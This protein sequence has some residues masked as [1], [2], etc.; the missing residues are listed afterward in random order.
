MRLSAIRV[1]GV[2]AALTACEEI[3]VP[4]LNNPDLESLTRNP[5]IGV[6]NTA[7][8]GM[9]INL[10]GRIGVE[11]SAMGILGKESYNLD[12]AEPRNVLSYLQGPIE[13][14]GFVQDLGWTEGYRNVVQGITILAAVDKITETPTP[15]TASY[16]LQQKEGIRGFVKTIMA[17]EL[18]TQVRIR[19]AVGIVLDVSADPSAP[20]GAVIPK[21]EALTRI[22]A[23]LNE[24]KTHLQNGGTA[25]AFQLHSGF[26][27][28]NTPSTFLRVN[29]AITARAEVYREQW[30]AALTALNES[31]IEATTATAAN[32]AR[33]AYHVFSL[34]SG[35]VLNTLFDQTPTRF[36]VHPSIL[37]GAQNR[38][39]GEPDLRLTQKTAPGTARTTVTV[40]GTHKFMNYPTNVSPVPIIKNEELILL[41]AEARYKTA[42][43]VGALAD[44][45]FIRVN[46]GGLAPLTLADIATEAAFVTE[47]LYNRTYSLLFE[48]G[49]RWVD[50]RRYGRLAQLPKINTQISEKTFPY[51][52]FPADECNQRNP[53]PQPACS[54]V[55]G[56]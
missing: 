19:D 47:L 39:S 38:P 32:L 44:L 1:I 52:M 7:T 24:A 13:P 3:T 14:G 16:S 15:T 42:D 51:V 8:V 22:V 56:Q 48:A 29:R 10:R 50:Y 34:T 2:A 41:R 18:L 21:A 54:E 43:L 40:Q 25:F 30:A 55:V 35:D 46:S 17:M 26:A 23:L 5:T 45:N 53:Q 12:Q 37:S 49:H 20:L 33:G 6:V 31:F 36:Y 11:A 28:F 4:N 27:G 9:L